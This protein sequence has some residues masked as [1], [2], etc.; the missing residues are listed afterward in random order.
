MLLPARSEWCTATGPSISPTMISALPAVSSIKEGSL[1]RSRGLM[2]FGQRLRLKLTD[3]AYQTLAILG[4]S[5][6]EF[7]SCNK[8]LGSHI[9]NTIVRPR[10]A[11]PYVG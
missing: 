11:K 6:R 4:G 5:R 1:T 3:Y 9:G 7:A 8:S 10:K 2:D